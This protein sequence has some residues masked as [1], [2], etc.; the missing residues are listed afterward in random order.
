MKPKEIVTAACQAIKRNYGYRVRCTSVKLKKISSPSTG[1]EDVCIIFLEFRNGI[2]GYNHQIS[3]NIKKFES[4]EEAYT[5]MPFVSNYV[6]KSLMYK[7]NPENFII[8][9]FAA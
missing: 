8:L 6:D 2:H 5:L 1:L 9:C 3:C 7:L 4:P